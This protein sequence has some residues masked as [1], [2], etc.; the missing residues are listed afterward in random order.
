[1]KD[2]ICS[3]PGKENVFSG[4]DG[5]MAVYSPHIKRAEGRGLSQCYVVGLTMDGDR[6]SVEPL[7]EKV[8]ALEKGMRRL[9]AD[10]K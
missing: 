7:S 1:V 9:L 4:I 10:V 6:K 8:Q 2:V 5:Y 3:L